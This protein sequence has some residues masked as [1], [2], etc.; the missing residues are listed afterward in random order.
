M[1]I[2]VLVVML[3]GAA[4]ADEDRS[5]GIESKSINLFSH[6]LLLAN[7]CECAHQVAKCKNKINEYEILFFD[8][9]N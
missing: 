4:I 1:L 9:I 2:L 6:V 7:V 5:N 8:N 3:L